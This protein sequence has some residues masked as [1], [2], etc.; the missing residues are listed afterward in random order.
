IRQA[1][2]NWRVCFINSKD[3]TSPQ[4]LVTKISADLEV[5]FHNN[6]NSL[7]LL[8]EQLDAMRQTGLNPILFIDDIEQLNKSII[9]TLATLIQHSP[10]TQPNL[11]L[12][13]AG[14]NITPD[15]KK[16]IPIYDKE[17]ALKC[18][19]LF[20]LTE[21]ENTAYIEHRLQV[22]NYQHAEPFSKIQLKK[23]H[24][25]A[26]GFP[27]QINQLADHLFSQYALDCANKKP[28]I[29]LNIRTNKQLKYVASGLSILILFV[30]IFSL[31]DTEEPE[32]ELIDSNTI[33]QELRIP[34]IQYKPET[35]LS[36]KTPIIEKNSSITHPIA[37]EKEQSIVSPSEKTTNKSIGIIEKKLSDNRTKIITKNNHWIIKQNPK[38]FTLQLISGGNKAAA[39]EFIKQHNIGK[40]A[41]IFHSTYKGRNWYSVI[42]KSFPSEKSAKE[43]R[44]YLPNSLRKIKPWVRTFS[45]VQKDM[46]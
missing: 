23:T 42:Y 15:L 3:F 8:R 12:V 20:P 17:I 11:R 45:T 19:P 5:K 18:L 29:N 1:K 35:E 24:L 46:K 30:I 2:D 10:E 27:A 32:I 34:N 36:V 44:K 40:D 43:G 13:I 33:I 31:F 38:H 7:D 4:S 21:V 25:S 28:L 16:I 26:K 22:A 37:I 41:T 39:K 9:V 14:Q 6:A